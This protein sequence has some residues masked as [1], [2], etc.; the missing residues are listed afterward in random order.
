MNMKRCLRGLPELTGF[1]TGEE[2]LGP[3]EHHQNHLTEAPDARTLC[4]R[5]CFTLGGKDSNMNLRGSKH[6]L[7]DYCCQLQLDSSCDFSYFFHYLFMSLEC[8]EF[9]M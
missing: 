5:T 9:N 2:N 7:L 1:C 3:L 6:N 8:V 4:G